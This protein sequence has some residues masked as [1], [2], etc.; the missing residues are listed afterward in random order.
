MISP[1]LVSATSLTA[2]GVAGTQLPAGTSPEVLIP[3]LISAVLEALRMF[4][5]YRSK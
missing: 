4:F 3:L 1:K 2:L 5:A